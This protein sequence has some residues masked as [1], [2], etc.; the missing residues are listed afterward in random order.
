MIGMI[1]SKLTELNG[2]VVQ[3]KGQIEQAI[4]N[5]NRMEGGSIALTSILEELEKIPTEGTPEQ[6]DDLFPQERKS[7]D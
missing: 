6:P 4:T 7:N 1:K 2:M 3:Q 5:L